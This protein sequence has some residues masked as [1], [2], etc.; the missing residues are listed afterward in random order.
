MTAVLRGE[1]L[2]KRYRGGDG[3]WSLRDISL[4]VDQGEIV[5]VIGRNGAGKSTLLKL[6]A[7]VTS[8]TEGHLW[9]ADRV[10]PLIEVGAGFHP[11]LTGRENVSVNARLLGMSAREIRARF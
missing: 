5:A 7:G 2:G 4:T 1:G 8:A 10:A 3:T 11:E 9:R 6:A